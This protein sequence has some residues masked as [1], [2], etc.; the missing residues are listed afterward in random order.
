MGLVMALNQAFG[1]QA[2]PVAAQTGGA[3]AGQPVVG[4]FQ[5]FDAYGLAVIDQVSALV[6]IYTIY[7]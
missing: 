3:T 7:T 1:Q 5:A 6:F 2:Q 4:A